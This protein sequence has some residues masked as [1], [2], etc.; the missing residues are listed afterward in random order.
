[1]KINCFQIPFYVED[2]DIDKIQ[3]SNTDFKE[4][5]LSKT[6]S[7]YSFKNFITKETHEYL[8]NLLHRMLSEDIKE[9]FKIK[10]I[11]IWQNIYKNKSYQEKHIHVHSHFSFIIYKKIKNSNTVFINPA[12][13][14]IESFY[15]ESKVNMMG[16]NVESNFKQNQIVLFPSFIEHM[17]KPCDDSETISGNIYIQ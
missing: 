11:N 12:N 3:L 17:V 2:I 1:L 10:L 4:T 8:L 13:K 6:L 5:W 15:S 14:L 7:S 9:E 16:V